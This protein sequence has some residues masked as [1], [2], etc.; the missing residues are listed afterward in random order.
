V[1]HSEYQ[2]LP[3]GHEADCLA[4]RPR[5]AARVLSVSERT[6]WGLTKQGRVPFV[7]IG[8]AVR[9][10]VHLLRK[11]LEEQAQAVEVASHE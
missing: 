11:W 9:Y 2:P 6:L 10:P 7:R 3:A 5:D 4:L 1:A 8:K